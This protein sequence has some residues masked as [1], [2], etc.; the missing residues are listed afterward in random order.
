MI[1]RFG[2]SWIGICMDSMVGGTQHV[3]GCT[4][5]YGFTGRLAGIAWHVTAMGAVVRRREQECRKRA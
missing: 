2:L 3:P 5:A 4:L 1:P